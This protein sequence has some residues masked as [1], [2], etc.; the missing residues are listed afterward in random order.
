MCVCV[1]VCVCVCFC[2]IKPRLFFG[3]CRCGGSR[4]VWWRRHCRKWSAW[5]LWQAERIS[6]LCLQYVL[7]SCCVAF[8]HVPRNAV[9][10]CLSVS[11][12]LCFDMH[13]SICL[14]LP[15]PPP[16][17]TLTLCLSVSLYVYMSFYPICL[18]AD[19]F[20]TLTESDT[21]FISPPTSV[22][23]TVCF[24][25]CPCLYVSVSVM[26]VCPCLFCF[27]LFFD[28]A[29]FFSVCPCLFLCLPRVCFCFRPIYFSL[30]SIQFAC[31][32]SKSC[33]LDHPN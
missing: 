31:M 23:L 12:F 17:P 21:L 8:V 1:C 5:F 26:S 11:I 28:S 15:P 9:C 14:S 24:A 16:P 7:G 4:V 13:V 22:C 20:Y 2:Q 32:I 27:V 10:V 30:V 25:V 33:S 18:P 19:G 6:L 29:C 3:C